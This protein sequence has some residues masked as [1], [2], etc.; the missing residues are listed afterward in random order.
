MWYRRVILLIPFIIFWASC[1]DDGP[2]VVKNP[3]PYNLSTPSYFGD[4]EIPVDNPLTVEGVALGRR[5]FYEK[6][7]SQFDSISCGSC[8]MQKNAFTDAIPLALGVPKIPIPR[9]TM[10]LANQL[11][12]QKFF[13]DGRVN[14]LEELIIFPLEDHREMNQSIEASIVKLQRDSNYPKLFKAAFGDE[15][16]T[17]D[18]IFKSISQFQRTLVSGDSKYDQYIRGE[19][20]PTSSELR[21]IDLFFTH[22]VAETGLRGGN[23]GDCHSSF[24]TSGFNN[25]FDGFHNNGLDS[26]DELKDGLFSV[27]GLPQDKGKFKAPTLR[28]IALTA[29]YMHDGRFNTLEE[30]LNHYNENIKESATLDILIRE[31]SNEV[32]VPGE[33]I[34]LQLTDQEKQDILAFLQMLTDQ[35]FINNEEFSD[36]FQE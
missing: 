36:P 22:P 25:G 26:D 20:M 12:N 6:Q 7:L 34:L 19:Y 11:W 23:C 17:S 18:R 24:L 5:L 15:N 13:W 30:V 28:N 10:S 14:S 31:A 33:P 27:T 21:G 32:V 35:N 4:F 1:S 8:H 9:N 29:P 3:T 2:D 16:I